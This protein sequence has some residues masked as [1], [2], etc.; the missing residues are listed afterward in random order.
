MTFSILPIYISTLASHHVVCPLSPSV[1]VVPPIPSHSVV[2]CLN[3]N[4][5]V[6]ARMYLCTFSSPP[7]LRRRRRQGF[8]LPPLHP[9]VFYFVCYHRAPCAAWLACCGHGGWL[10][11][12][13]PYLCWILHLDLH[14][15]FVQSM[16]STCLELNLTC[17]GQ[18]MGCRSS[19][20]S[21][22][23]A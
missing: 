20:L 18:D 15:F 8:Y 10:Y 1:S 21:R 16:C 7:R 3:M 19:F 6:P 9:P 23:R 2:R 12:I 17:E 13:Y 5:Y 22:G 11:M 4:T 14:I